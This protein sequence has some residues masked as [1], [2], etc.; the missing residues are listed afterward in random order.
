[1]DRET[2]QNNAPF[3][4]RDT[5]ITT[6]LSSRLFRKPGPGIQNWDPVHSDNRV[7]SAG[8]SISTELHL[9][10]AL[11]HLVAVDLFLGDHQLFYRQCGLACQLSPAGVYDIFTVT[12]LLFLGR[13]IR[14]TDLVNTSRP[15][16]DRGQGF[17]FCNSKATVR[18]TIIRFAT[19][20]FINMGY[21]NIINVINAWF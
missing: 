6:Q 1:M 7:Q 21:V 16:A 9:D 4:H 3:L 12:C 14:L 10:V 18:K 2:T 19:N 20:I 5:A 17:G 13:S 15:T 11:K 8:F